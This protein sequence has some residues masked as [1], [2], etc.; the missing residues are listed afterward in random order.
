MT[1]ETEE[2][3]DIKEATETELS[4]EVVV[5]KEKLSQ[6][7]SNKIRAEKSYIVTKHYLGQLQKEQQLR[8]KIETPCKS[9]EVHSRY[10]FAQQLRIELY[11]KLGRDLENGNYYLNGETAKNILKK[12]ERCNK[13][14]D[15]YL[16]K[17]C[18]RTGVNEITIFILLCIFRLF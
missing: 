16:K 17:Y 13:I 9:D 10:N 4:A 3:L 15:W 5:I 7:K 1:P 14:A 6:L 18:V 2:V 11:C 12:I 8:W